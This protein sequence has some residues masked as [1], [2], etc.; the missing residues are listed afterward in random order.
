MIRHLA[1]CLTLI[2]APASAQVTPQLLPESEQAA[3]NAIGRVNV[4]G[5]QRRGMCTGTLVAPDLVLTA[6]H[7]LYRANGT[8]ARPI[9][10]HF[11]AG[12]RKG[13]YRSHRRGA[14]VHVH[15]DYRADLPPLAERIPFDVGLVLLDSPIPDAEVTPLP[16]AELPDGA[17]DFTLIGYRRDRPHAPSRQ[18]GCTLVHR[19]PGAFGLD[20]P[21]IPGASGG[22]VLSEETD[23]W[24]VVGLISASVADSLP[25]RSLAATVAPDDLLAT[26]AY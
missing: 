15:P 10:V 3:W 6:A 20:C 12:W 4:A 18:T 19:Q 17:P 14:E 21:V 9:D 8:P 25:V 2:A 11:V 16:L 13:A 22:P 23:G 24:K 1:L 26:P 5:L 7:C